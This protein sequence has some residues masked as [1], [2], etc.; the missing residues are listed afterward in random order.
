MEKSDILDLVSRK[1]TPFM[2][3]FGFYLLAY[4]H[5]SPGGGFQGG[6]VIAS[7]V[8]LMSVS[9]GI[10][11][12]ERLYPHRALSLIEAGGFLL[13][14]LIGVAGAVYGSGFL[15]LLGGAVEAAE[16]PRISLILIFN[17]IIGLKVGAGISLICIR[18]F[19]EKGEDV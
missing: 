8:I 6:V 2:L 9:R 19:Q 7:A 5:L 11:A 16:G 4:G 17:V 15:S 13:L 3:L 14:L 10:E 1:L 12:V 18:L